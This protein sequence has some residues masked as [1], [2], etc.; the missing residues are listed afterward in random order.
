MRRIA[1]EAQVDGQDLAGTAAAV[2]LALQDLPLPAGTFISVGGRVET[3]ARAASV[4]TMAILVS[5]LLVV[6]LLLIALGSLAETLAVVATLPDAL[7]GGVVALWLS[8]GSWNVSS[9]V[10][11]MALLGIAVQN[12]L[13]LVTQAREL[14]GTGMDAR[15]AVKEASLGRVRPKIMTAL[16]AILGLL[17][18]VLM[19]VRGAELERPMAVVMVGGLITSTLFTLLAL[20]AFYL[21]VDRL[22]AS[23]REE[24]PYL[25]K[26]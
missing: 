20:P 10:G 22:R 5:A 25:A 4:L 7:V 24:A 19:D 11:M 12:G 2:R 15:S 16:T 9:A 18:L 13:V 17:P 21:F 3:Q 1:V 8:G 6:I 14:M 23:T 26:K